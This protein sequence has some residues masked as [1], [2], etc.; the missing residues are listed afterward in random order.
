V[1]L[2]LQVNGHTALYD[3]VEVRQIETSSLQL[4]MGGALRLTPRT[5]L[6]LAVVEDAAIGTAPDVGFH[7]NLRGD[8]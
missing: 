5:R 3:D 1:A 7:L 6:E 4:V 2:Q 8:F